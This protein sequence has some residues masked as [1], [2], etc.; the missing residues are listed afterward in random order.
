MS[1]LYQ[2]L[3]ELNPEVFEDLCFQIISE[4]HPGVEINRVHG[5]GGDKGVDVFEGDLSGRPTIWQCKYFVNGVK[6]PQKTQIKKSI[7]AALKNFR[8]KRWILC[9]PVNLDINGHAW[10]QGLKLEY[11]NRCEI[12]LFQASHIVRELLH[13]RTLRNVFF[14]G[15]VLDTHELRS[16]LAGTGDYTNREIEKLALE[17]VQQYLQR[18]RDRDARFDYQI[19]YLP[20]R[21]LPIDNRGQILTVTNEDTRIDVFPKDVEALALDP[22]RFRFSL[23][24]SGASKLKKSIETGLP[25]DFGPDEVKNF[26]SSLDFLLPE[27]TQSAGHVLVKPSEIMGG[28][29]FTFRVTFGS[30][31][32]S[33]SYPSLEFAVVRAGTK[34]SEL[35]TTDTDLPFQLAIVLEMPPEGPSQRVPIKG[36]FSVTHQFP[37]RSA[38]TIKK[39]IDAMRALRQS[40]EIELYDVRHESLFFKAT[41]ELEERSTG[42]LQFAQLI[43]E[44]AEVSERLDIDLRLPESLK[45]EDVEN[46]PVLL[47]LI[48][49]GKATLSVTSLSAT[50]VKNPEHQAQ[51][52]GMLHEAQTLRLDF[53]NH[54]IK[55]AGTTV[56][57][58]PCSLTLIDAYII[59]PERVRRE[60]LSADNGDGIVVEMRPEGR[61]TLSSPRF[62][63]TPT[64]N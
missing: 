42:Y 1:A 51:V 23:S 13:R 34:E 37:G 30:G 32:H 58:G 4:R 36:R 52:L 47:E 6:S 29:R 2:R 22:P 11:R 44:L 60:Y 41:L 59:D 35:S 15:I 53:L 61:V 63:Q 54:S 9:L 25:A 24:P 48:R 8:A 31:S 46:L 27:G 38:R 56:E 20:E 64:E 10:L 62:S 18:L 55:L 33:I 7:R 28:R 43:D 45:E 40:R 3:R 49:T 26:Q 12:G 50:L 57:I 14:P 39:F 16:L 5:A 21:P 17:N 19:T